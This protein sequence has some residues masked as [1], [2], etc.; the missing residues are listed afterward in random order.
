[1]ADSQHPIKAMPQN[2]FSIVTLTGIATSPHS[3]PADLVLRRETPLA[4]TVLQYNGRDPSDGLP[5]KSRLPPPRNLRLCLS[6]V[7]CEIGSGDVS[8][9]YA[10]EV[11]PSRSTPHLQGRILPPLVVKVSRR[12][13]ANVLRAEAQNYAEMEI[14]QGHVIP[15]CYGL[16]SAAIPDDV[17]FWPW[18][19]DAQVAG[20]DK[21]Y[22]SLPEDEELFI[23]NVVT[24]LVMERL[25]EQAAVGQ[26]DFS[27]I[28]AM[29]KDISSL[30]LCHLDMSEKNILKA[31]KDPALPV[32][33]SPHWTK[34]YDFRIVDFHRTRRAN[35][36][37]DLVAV[38]N[39][40]ALGS[41]FGRDV[42][43]DMS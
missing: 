13:M 6:L 21:S 37:N 24:I 42:L 11:V 35:L 39:V 31:P 17:Q 20:D 43:T 26:E 15:R 40:M 22:H 16:Y 34:P 7:G 3:P 27:E 41:L 2:A 23:P 19:G 36:R 29:Y 25:G 18:E 5:R 10:A 14:L 38:R 1:M 12:G 32:R 30:G 4:N 8:R 33:T 9:V 28:Q